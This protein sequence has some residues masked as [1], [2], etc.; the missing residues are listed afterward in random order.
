MMEETAFGAF[1]AMGGYAEF[2]WPAYGVTGLV[3][4]AIWLDG[5]RR[6]RAVERALQRLARDGS[7]QDAQG[8]DTGRNDA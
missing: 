7:G 4:L 5:Y 6:R 2:V 1:L 8:R 3:L